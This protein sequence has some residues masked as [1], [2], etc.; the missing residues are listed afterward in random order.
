L[1]DPSKLYSTLKKERINSFYGVP[2]SVLKNFTSILN[3]KEQ[4]HF[5][6]ANEGLAV[7]GA[8][9]NYLSS[10]KIPLVYMQNSGLGNSINPLVSIAHNGVYGIPMLLMI[11][12]RG[13]DGKD[14]PQHNIKG[15]I[16]KKILNLLNIKFL[17]IETEKDLKSISK[18]INFAKKNNSPV[19]LLI[20]TNSLIQNKSKI[21]FNNKNKLSREE[22]IR[23]ILDNLP[24]KTSVVSTTG[25]T[26]REIN[27][28]LKNNKYK[29]IKYLYMVGGMGHSSMVSFGVAN[30]TK[31]QV[32]CLDGD[33][34]FMMHLGSVITTG[35]KARK[36]F[37]HIMLNNFC[38]ESVGKQQIDTNLV[39][40][41][42]LTKAFGYKKYFKANNL[43]QLKSNIAK[44]IKCDGPCFF[45]ILIST[46]SMKNLG[47][48]KNFK[49]IKKEFMKV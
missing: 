27:E 36:N 5:V 40:F 38:H 33:G 17:V 8:I 32:I 7:A 9:G 15:K 37:K 23:V 47:R 10:K 44:F 16:T 46:Q 20:K 45:E 39:D 19:A 13:F 42:S 35:F 30:N 22:G 12:W 2:D 24:K 48:P 29:N 14:E 6:T 31:N 49:N 43:S 21:K 41:K 4:N 11:G 1:I 18:L 28:I 3:N 25:Y 26:S 34:A